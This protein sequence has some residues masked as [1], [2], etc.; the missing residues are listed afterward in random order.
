MANANGF[1]VNRVYLLS[2]IRKR[3]LTLG[4]FPMYI[5]RGFRAKFLVI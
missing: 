5:A 4:S 2:V 1:T 3:T